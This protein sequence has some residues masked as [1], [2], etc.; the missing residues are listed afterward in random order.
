MRMRRD[1]V[2]GTIIVHWR[3]ESGCRLMRGELRDGGDGDGA[4]EMVGHALQHTEDDEE[5]GTRCVERSEIRDE[6]LKSELP[7][8]TDPPSLQ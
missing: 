5:S 1:E 2:D 6:R 7:V 4:K 3:V 8:D